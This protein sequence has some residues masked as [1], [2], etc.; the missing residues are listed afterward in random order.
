MLGNGFSMEV[1]GWLNTPATDAMARMPWLGSL[2]VGLQKLLSANCKAKFSLQDVFQTNRVN[3][4]I[5]AADI[6]TTTGFYMET[7]I[8]LLNLTYTFGNQQLKGSRQ[9]QICSDD[10]TKRAN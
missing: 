9:R 2:D 10:E 6:S 4:R 8:A 7:K 1:T 3:R 5:Q